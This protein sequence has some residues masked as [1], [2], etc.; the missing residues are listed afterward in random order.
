MIDRFLSTLGLARKAGKLS[1]GS[2]TVS[3]A[4]KA[5]KV[6]VVFTA[7]DLSARSVRN[8]DEVCQQRGIPC[9]QTT[10]DMMQLGEAVGVY[11]G[12]LAITDSGLAKIAQ[13]KLDNSPKEKDESNKE[14]DI[15][16]TSKEDS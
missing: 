14:P 4:V 10:Y 1:W 8:I 3:N 7:A 9:Y 12:I 15:T 11:T 6:A 13:S 16:L 5:G 2:E